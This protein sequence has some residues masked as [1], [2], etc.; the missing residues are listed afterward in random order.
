MAS[1]CE[2][3]LGIAGASAL[4]VPPHSC[5]RDYLRKGT[6]RSMADGTLRFDYS[7]SGH[8]R[9]R[10]GWEKISSTDFTTLEAEA[11][12]PGSMLWSP[13]T[14]STCWNV[15]VT[16]FRAQPVPSRGGTV[17]WNVGLTLETVDD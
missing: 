7:A 17:R 10:V 12:Y 11:E 1:A 15:L 14:T 5:D 9:W 3:Y 4:L 13:P 16:S 8:K 6:Y 2:T